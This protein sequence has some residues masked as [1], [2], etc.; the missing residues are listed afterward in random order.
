MCSSNPAKMGCVIVRYDLVDALFQWLDDTG[1]E[2]RNRHE[3]PAE[4]GRPHEAVQCVRSRGA[5]C[6]GI[7]MQRTDETAKRVHT[8]LTH[9]SALP[10]PHASVRD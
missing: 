3:A 1:S 7:T 10:R 5:V 2:Y 9:E 8:G 6:P 4:L